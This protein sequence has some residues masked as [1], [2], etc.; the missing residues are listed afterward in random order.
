MTPAKPL[1]A[2]M[3]AEPSRFSTGT[4]QFSKRIV[5]VSEARMPSLCSRRSTVM[6]GVSFMTTNDLIA[7]RP[8]DLSSVAQTT[9]ASQRPPAVT[10]I[11]SPSST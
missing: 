7:A 4:R 5:A 6:P 1:S 10:K 3:S 8:S 2:S 11:F 9:T